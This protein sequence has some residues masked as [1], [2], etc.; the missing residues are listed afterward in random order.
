M[1]ISRV[2]VRRHSVH[3]LMMC[4]SLLPL[5]ATAAAADGRIK[6]YESTFEAFTSALEPITFS[7]RY[8]LKVGFITVCNSRYSGKVDGLSVNITPAGI[9]VQGEVTFSWCNLNFGSREPELTGLGRVSYHSGSGT[10]RVD[11]DTVVYTPKVD[12]LEWTF[13]LPVSINL[14]SMLDFPPLPFRETFIA[15]ELPDGHRYVK[16]S[17]VNVELSL[18]N[19][20]LQLTSDA[21]M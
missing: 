10:I 7:G 6:V 18:H 12:I 16:L 15:F 13:T 5:C 21:V 17:P 2:K 4:A 8:I 9:I 1:L 20:Y 3:R 19:G 11:F 14:G